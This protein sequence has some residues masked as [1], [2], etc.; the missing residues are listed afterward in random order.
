MS[1][2]DFFNKYE[3][4]IVGL[5]AMATLG[6]FCVTMYQVIETRQQIRANFSYHIHK[7]GREIRKSIDNEII[8][9]LKSPDPKQEYFKDRIE[10]AQNIIRELLMYYVAAYHQKSYGNI[11]ENEWGY[12]EKEFC[13]FLSYYQ[14][15]KYWK[16]RIAN[17]E[18][19]DKEFR[20]LG[21]RCLSKKGDKNENS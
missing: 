11:T 15:E 10:K 12:M 9:I 16:E 13:N 17:N 18:L 14:V 5:A 8:N 7:D 4:M 21:E 1:V 20:D 2:L 6:A 3:K 19:W